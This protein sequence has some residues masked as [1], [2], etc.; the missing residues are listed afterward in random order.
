M[1]HIRNIVRYIL[2]VLLDKQ[3]RTMKR[4]KKEE[5]ERKEQHQLNKRERIFACP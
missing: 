3:H 1:T 2:L 4:K 5:R